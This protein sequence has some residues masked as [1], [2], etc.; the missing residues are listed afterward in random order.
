MYEFHC[1]VVIKNQEIDKANELGLINDKERDLQFTG[2]LKRLKTRLN[3]APG[4][5]PEDAFKLV[6]SNGSVTLHFSGNW[7]H[8]IPNAIEIFEWI[9]VNAPY[10]YG[11]L[12]IYDNECSGHPD[13]F[14][15]YRLA[16]NSITK[17][18]DS[19]LSPYFKAVD[20]GYQ[21]E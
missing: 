8:A 15:V 2:L 11:L 16:R 4:G 19:Y 21:E 6:G 1:W 10:S 14:V 20:E 17:L 3:V 5:L 9:R 12:Y 7:N 13:D 18:P